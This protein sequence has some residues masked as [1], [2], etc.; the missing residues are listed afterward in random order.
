MILKRIADIFEKFGVAS[1]VIGLYKE[2]DT[3]INL[4]GI[5]SL[6]ISVA[7]TAKGGKQ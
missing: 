1:L 5:F 6:A 4:V 3:I 7:L 2:G